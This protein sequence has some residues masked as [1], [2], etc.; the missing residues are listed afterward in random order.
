M[1]NFI[2]PAELIGRL[3]GEDYRPLVDAYILRG[4]PY[5]FKESPVRYDTLRHELS[6]YLDVRETNLVLVGSARTGFSLSP[7]NF[8][9]PFRDDSDLDMAVVS[10]R[11]FDSVWLDLL[12]LTPRRRAAL[13]DQV[14]KYVQEHRTYRIFYGR[15]EPHRLVGAA[16][17][18]GKWFK[19]FRSVGR[20]PEL[21]RHQ[22]HG[23]LF[24][25]WEHAKLYYIYGLRQVT[26]QLSKRRTIR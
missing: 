20:I 25:T 16:T 8:G 1:A 3:A 22:I 17:L 5:V 6:R 15:A 11:L 24:R 13:T 18:T 7:D 2:T 4:T 23:M 12:H 9:R 21:S 19:A 14:E 26:A 10:A